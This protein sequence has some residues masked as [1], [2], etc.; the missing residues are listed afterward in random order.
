[1]NLITPNQE[2]V[3]IFN[4]FWT[5]SPITNEIKLFEDKGKMDIT[6]YIVQFKDYSKKDRTIRDTS[7]L[8]A[9]LSEINSVYHTRV[10]GIE[11]LVTKLNRIKVTTQEGLREIIKNQGFTL[12][13]FVNICKMSSG[14]YTYS[15]ATKVF[16][17]I[18]DETYPII[19]SFVS[20][21]LDNYIYEDKIPKSKWGDYSKY[22]ENYLNFMKH[23]KLNISFKN[24]D[25]FLWTYCKI[26]ADYWADMGVLHFEP[27]A[28]DTNTLKESIWDTSTL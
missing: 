23:Y 18:D 11:K 27:V 21:L 24:V 19:D 20:T 8:S 16:S 13:D 3:E 26:L 25:K 7:D 5:E 22:K 14:S 17:F 9:F 15:F 1:M 12:E 6:S 10:K 2:V 28:F 4:S